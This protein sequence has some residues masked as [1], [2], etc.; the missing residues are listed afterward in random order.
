MAAF[1]ITWQF[2]K[3]ERTLENNRST[4]S[5]SFIKQRTGMKHGVVVTMVIGGEHRT[6]GIKSQEDSVSQK[7]HSAQP[8]TFDFDLETAAL[9]T[10]E[11]RELLG[12][13]HGVVCACNH[14]LVSRFP[15]TDIIKQVKLHT[16]HDFHPET[17][18]R[19]A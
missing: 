15:A 11:Q 19:N 4:M 17:W 18:K 13:V 6:P 7:E 9:G 3:L 5:S 2:K 16:I 10:G 8:D 14:D 1:T 12:L